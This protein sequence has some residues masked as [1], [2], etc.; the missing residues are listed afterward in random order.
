MDSGKTMFASYKFYGLINSKKQH[1]L[2]NM[3]STEKYTFQNLKQE[4]S[5][6][7]TG[8]LFFN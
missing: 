7:I 2:N 5:L 8:G 4:R 6:S 1:I 3:L